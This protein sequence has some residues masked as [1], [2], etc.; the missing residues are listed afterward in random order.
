MESVE[1]RTLGADIC[2][3]LR[4]AG[5]VEKLEQLLREIG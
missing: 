4:R 2:W 5:I 3:K 1:L